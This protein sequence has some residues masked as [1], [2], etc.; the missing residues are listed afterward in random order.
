MRFLEW[1]GVAF[2][3]LAF[4][5]RMQI[6]KSESRQEYFEGDSGNYAGL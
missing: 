4:C 5:A 1:V 6:A 3:G 2:Y